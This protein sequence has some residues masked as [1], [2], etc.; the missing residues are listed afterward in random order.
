MN[1][2][3]GVPSTKFTLDRT[4]V[5]SKHFGDSEPT[6]GIHG[7]GTAARKCEGLTPEYWDN[8]GPD[9]DF[10]RVDDAV[11]ADNIAA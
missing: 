7:G 3:G 10:D 4:L 1:H 2:T 5:R 6:G 9:D 11:D 8:P